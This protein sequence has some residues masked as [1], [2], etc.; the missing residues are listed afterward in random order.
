[1]S[2][3]KKQISTIL[4]EYPNGSSEEADI[5]LGWGDFSSLTSSEKSDADL[6]TDKEE[7]LTQNNN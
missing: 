3:D 5:V 4:I 1:M 7:A 6:E 2:N